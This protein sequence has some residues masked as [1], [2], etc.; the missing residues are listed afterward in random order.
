MSL[1]EDFKATAALP[2]DQGRA[3]PLQCY[4]DPA[5][6]EEEVKNVFH[7]DWVFVCGA[8]A[9]KEPGDRFAVTIAGEPVVIMRG[10]DGKLRALSNVCT[11]RGTPLADPGLGQGPNLVCPYHSWNFE[12]DGTLKG[13]PYTGSVEI[14]K[15]AHCLP[16]YALEEWCG[17]VFVNI[18]GNAAP[19]AER[20][21]PM[22]PYMQL[23]NCANPQF[24]T[25]METEIWAS[26]WKLVMENA[27]ESYHLFKVHKPTLETV[28]PTKAA[29]YVEGCEEWCL[30]AGEYVGL[31]D[32]ARKLFGSEKKGPK[33]HYML[34]SLPPS[35]VGIASADGT[36]GYISMLPDGPGKTYARGGAVLAKEPNRSKMEEEFTAAF[37]AEDKWICERAYTGMLSRNAKGGTFVELERIVQDFHRYLGNRLCGQELGEVFRNPDIAEKGVAA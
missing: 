27:M 12:L 29:F 6:Y 2:A 15:S 20:Y 37:F 34:I 33:H 7:R 32:P 5:F 11:H 4:S 18:D 28:T 10:K 19:L 31:M 35:F 1:M 8:T 25:E 13:A 24:G 9:L 16:E 23:Y 3:I 36:L 26:N 14:D 30:T 21:A 17:L 22:M